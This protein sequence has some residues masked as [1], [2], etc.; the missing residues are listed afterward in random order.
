MVAL[1]LP[2][3]GQRPIIVYGTGVRAGAMAGGRLFN[4][5]RINW[6]LGIFALEMWAAAWF[7][8]FEPEIRAWWR[9]RRMMRRWRTS[10]APRRAVARRQDRAA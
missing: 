1:S 10:H 9:R 6:F 5:I 3:G 2:L 4:V 7:V 8:A